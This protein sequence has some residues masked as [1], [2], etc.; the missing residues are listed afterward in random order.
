MTENSAVGVSETA[1]PDIQAIR[2]RCE[3]TTPGRWI[4][5]AQHQATG[6]GGRTPGKIIGYI[7]EYL[8]KGKS[9]RIGWPSLA[10]NAS[11]EG[12]EAEHPE[13]VANGEFI[14]SAHTDIPELLS[15]IESLES[16]LREAIA[17]RGTQ[18][19]GE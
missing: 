6:W 14:A 17:S 18:E 12:A 16:R 9:G 15:H 10:W 19:A 4:C 8:H 2:E 7:V 3:A 11:N 5:R 1:R 13:N